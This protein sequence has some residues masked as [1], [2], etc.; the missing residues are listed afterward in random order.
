MYKVFILDGHGGYAGEFTV[1]DTCVVEFSE[2][3]QHVPEGGLE[4]GHTIFLNEWRATSVQGDN[5]GLVVISRGQ[6]GPEEVGWAK[7]ALTAAEAQLAVEDT[8]ENPAP[9]P[10]GPDK[11]VMESLS[12]AITEREEQLAAREAV[13]R[14]M[15]GKTESAVEEFRQ[16]KEVEIAELK[17]EMAAARAQH[18]ADVKA[19][20]AEREAVRK[21][22]AA[23]AQAPRPTAP[24]AADPKVEAARKQNEADRKHL[25]KYALD[26][27]AREEAARDREL[28]MEG[29]AKRLAAMRE[30]IEKLRA[31]VQAAKQA[32]PSPEEVAAKRELETRVKVLEQKSIE[33]LQREEKLQAREK[34]LY[35]TLKQIQ[36]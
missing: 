1:D 17:S 10:T 20:E 14:E 8:D 33:L 28:A 3:L 9:P 32:G 31:E 25:Q 35:D 36:M 12:K 5:M 34:K 24:P 4:D 30:E 15:Q 2:F 7:A 23:I 27:I 21:Q 16:Q 22:M 29:E 18:D 19:L 6:L 26:V 13:L 11:A